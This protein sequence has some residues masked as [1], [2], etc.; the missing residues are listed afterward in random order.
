MKLTYLTI[1]LGIFLFFWPIN[2][3]GAENTLHSDEK[4]IEKIEISAED[5][6]VIQMM[7][8]LIMMD[9]LETMELLDEE[10]MAVTED[11]K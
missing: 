4:Q 11:N 6:Q 8:L 1:F 5:L 7:D 9:F 10:I 3:L 2:R